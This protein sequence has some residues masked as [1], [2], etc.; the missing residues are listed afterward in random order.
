VHEDPRV[1][2]A[3]QAYGAFSVEHVF[4]LCPAETP[5]VPAQA[6]IVLRID[7]GKVALGQRDSAEG[8]AEAQTPPEQY[9]PKQGPNE[10]RWKLECNGELYHHPPQKSQNSE[11]RILNVRNSLALGLRLPF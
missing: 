11:Y 1:F 3:G 9:E 7:Y 6:L 8:V 2:S 5:F 4:A 10:P